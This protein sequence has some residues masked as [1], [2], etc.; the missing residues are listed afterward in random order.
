MNNH[1][2]PRLPVLVSLLV[3]KGIA[4]LVYLDPVRSADLNSLESV[5]IKKKVPLF[6]T[7]GLCKILTPSRPNGRKLLSPA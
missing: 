1:S 7:T 6:N 2:S 5:V 4:L 3:A